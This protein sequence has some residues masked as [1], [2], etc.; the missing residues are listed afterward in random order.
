[1]GPAQRPQHTP[2]NGMRGPPP[3]LTAKGWQARVPGRDSAQARAPPVKLEAH[4][5]AAGMREPPSSPWLMAESM[6]AVTWTR[7]AGGIMRY[8]W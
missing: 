5:T 3:G 2:L 1:M 8:A 6:A 7:A 4:T